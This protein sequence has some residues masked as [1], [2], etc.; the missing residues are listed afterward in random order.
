[1][2]MAVGPE[3]PLIRRPAVVYPIVASFRRT[4]SQGRQRS[5][6]WRPLLGRCLCWKT[7]AF[8]RR[9]GR[10]ASRTYLPPSSK[11]ANRITSLPVTLTGKAATLR[12]QQITA[13]L[14]P[15]AA[16]SCNNRVYGGFAPRQGSS[17]PPL[18]WPAAQHRGNA[19][20]IAENQA[21]SV[22]GTARQ[23]DEGLGWAIDK[24]A[25]GRE[26]KTTRE[27]IDTIDAHTLQAAQIGGGTKPQIEVNR[28]RIAALLGLRETWTRPDEVY[29]DEA[30]E[31]CIIWRSGYGR[32]EIGTEEDG[33][34]TYYVSRTLN[35]KSGEGTL[36]EHSREELA[37]IMSWLDKTHEGV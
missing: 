29:A 4:M 36:Q 26:T 19:G 20:D 31:I 7:R 32:V 2:N 14:E 1:M 5:R 17:Q 22:N 15:W 13:F 35:E 28:D 37:R 12:R 25:T 34:I 18:P 8:M 9:P 24:S 6:P 27:I 10:W 23:A 11:T 3:P 21:R 30:W 16:S 33:S